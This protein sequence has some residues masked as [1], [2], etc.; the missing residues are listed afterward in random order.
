MRRQNVS[1]T[2]PC[3]AARIAA[4]GGGWLPS[5]EGGPV[6]A[7]VPELRDFLRMVILNK[8]E[9]GHVVDGLVDELHLMVSPVV[10][11][12]GTPIFEGQ[13][14]SSLRLIGASTW[15]GSGIVLLK[16]EPNP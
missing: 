7:T 14:P 8:E 11:G 16:Y 10:S 4:V 6:F 15:E 2:R 12:T 1:L 13:P 5:P 3:P 9:Q